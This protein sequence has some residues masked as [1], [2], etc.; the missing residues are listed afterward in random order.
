MIGEKKL[1]RVQETFSCKTKLIFKMGPR[2]RLL[3]EPGNK[4]NKIEDN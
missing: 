2:A 1:P 4:Q 3:W